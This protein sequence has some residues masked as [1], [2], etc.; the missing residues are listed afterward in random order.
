MSPIPQSRIYTQPPP[1]TYVNPPTTTYITPNQSLPTPVPQVRPNPLPVNP[2][3]TLKPNSLPDRP[4]ENLLKANYE[5]V[6]LA[7]SY[8]DLA[9]AFAAIQ[10][11][12]QRKLDE[13]KDGL[14]PEMLAD[15]GVAAA[16]DTIQSEIDNGEPISDADI[17][18][19]INAVTV[20]S[21]N[22]VPVTGGLDPFTAI[23]TLGGIQAL[24]D[25][26]QLVG[27]YPPG[28]GAI[29]LPAG[30]IDIITDPLLP[31]DAVFALPSGAIMDGTG[32]QGGFAMG[33]GTLAEAMGLPPGAGDPVP[34]STAD[35]NDRTTSGLLIMNP[36]LNKVGI[37]YVV[38]GQNF[39]TPA[40]YNQAIPGTGNWIAQ[41]NRGPGFGDARY[42]LTEGTYYWAATER[43][44][45]L[46]NREFSV[47]ISN[48]ENPKSFEYVVDNTPAN[49]AGGQSRTHTSKFPMTVHFDRGGGNQPAQKQ[50]NDPT[51][52]KFQV[53]VAINTDDNLWD[54]YPAKNFAASTA[55]ATGGSPVPGVPSTGND[56][57]TAG[58]RTVQFTP[59]PAAKQGKVKFA[60]APAKKEHKV[61]EWKVVA[62]KPATL[63]AAPVPEPPVD[64]P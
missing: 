8:D 25:L 26:Q 12:Q 42:A 32:G 23:Q 57:T 41:F 62:K 29:P 56:A 52:G 33:Q 9:A 40:G 34:A 19:L 31:A 2:Q 55:V 4:Q 54:L 18:N 51:A 7:V 38:N 20:A 63:P 60:P 39:S 49:I 10:E 5:L 13:I 46:Y 35:P 45:E 58:P 61:P 30:L 21:N 16:I 14:G 43:G 3:A 27:Q 24:G 36:P 17:D 59:L 37:E 48:A 28:G 50:F 1:T 44:W 11:E 53:R 22:G 47:T 6:A 15:P 64:K